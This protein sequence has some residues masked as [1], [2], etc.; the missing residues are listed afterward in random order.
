MLDFCSYFKCLLVL[1]PAFVVSSC[2]MAK[3]VT[4]IPQ[5]DSVVVEYRE[6]IVHDTAYFE[7]PVVIDK[8]MTLDTMSHLENDWAKSDASVTDGI[9]SHSLETIPRVVKV[10]VTV[11]VHDTTY[12]ERQ[13]SVIT[14][15]V[16]KPLSR[17]QKL[18]L[19]LGEISLIIAI[20]AVIILVLRQVK[21]IYL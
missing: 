17:W 6:R 15:E 12:I 18:L 20:T 21:K 7:V 1:V 2:G 16:I 3:R 5:S 19:K 13:A 8:T 14:H 9:L 10:P 11:E 4:I